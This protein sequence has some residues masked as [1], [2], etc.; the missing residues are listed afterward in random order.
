MYA[1]QIRD[2]LRQK[3]NYVSARVMKLECDVGE[4]CKCHE[5]LFEIANLDTR[6]VKVQ[7]HFNEESF[8]VV[9]NGVKGKIS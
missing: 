1:I 3:K 8:V 4:N 6:L 7:E 5:C 9:K 2:Y